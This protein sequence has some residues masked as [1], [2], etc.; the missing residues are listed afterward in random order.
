MSRTDSSPLLHRAG[1]TMALDINRNELFCTACHDYVYLKAF[2][3]ATQASRLFS[4]RHLS[5]IPP[6]PSQQNNLPSPLFPYRD[7]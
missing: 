2:D 3:L 6:S 4:P 5:S 1:H 7:R